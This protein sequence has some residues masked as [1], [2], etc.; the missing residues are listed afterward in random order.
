MKVGT[1]WADITPAEKLSVAG[2]MVERIAQYTHDPLTVNA[3]VFADGDIKAAIVSCD[4]CLIP[5]SFVN[6]TREEC[7]ARTGIPADNILIG[8][9]HSHVAPN[10]IDSI[11][12]SVSP[13]FM[14]DFKAKIVK[15]VENAVADLEESQIFAGRGFVEQMGFNR[16][17]MHDNGQCDMYWGSWCENFEGLEGPR[18]GEVPLLFA[19]REDGTI[20][21]VVLSFSTHPNSVEGESFYSA[22]VAGAVRAYLRR[23]LGDD[24]GVVYLTGAAGNTA[25]SQLVDNVE[26]IQPWRGEEGW[27]RSGMY[28]GSEVIKTIAG[29]IDPMENPKLVLKKETL[30]IPIMDYPDDPRISWDHEHFREAKRDWPRKKLE[31][32][33]YDVRVNVIRIGDAAICTSPAELYVEHGLAIKKKSPAEVTLISE[34]TDGFVGYVATQEA[35][36]H[37]GYSTWPAEGCKLAHDAGDQIVASSDRM[38]AEAFKE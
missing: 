18:D 14:A 12:G 5:D 23:N 8:A 7:S 9:T 30:K 24:L 34:L 16:R 25:P 10:T 29:T 4:I 37:G 26:N 6:Q 3:V 22:D 35:Y 20:K 31:E 27:K 2:Q 11:P 32:S 33:P 38:L 17:G 15:S 36:K 1:A 28:L 19:K 21:V 13:A